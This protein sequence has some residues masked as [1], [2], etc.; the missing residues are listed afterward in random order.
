[1]KPLGIV[2]LL[3]GIFIILITFLTDIGSTSYAANWAP[4]LG[5]L[6]FITGG[7]SYF[8]ARNEE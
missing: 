1:M 3:S 8:M 2:L 7:V 4:W 5:I 6:V